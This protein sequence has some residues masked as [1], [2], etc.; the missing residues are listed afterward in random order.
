M[1]TTGV[2]RKGAR[3]R[4]LRDI[5]VKAMLHPAGPATFA[6]QC[7][8]R[9]GTVFVVYSDPVPITGLFACVVEDRVTENELLRTAGLDDT[10]DVRLSF[11]FT[12]RDVGRRL[13]L[14]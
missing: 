11:R 9:R 3:L 5:D 1:R 7:P 12:L 4:A 13:E 2:V 8:I 6:V 14:L 10:S